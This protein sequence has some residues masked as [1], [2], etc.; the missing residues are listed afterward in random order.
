MKIT[1]PC[2]IV[3]VF[4]THFGL[5]GEER[6]HQVQTVVSPDWMSDVPAGQAAVLL[7]DFNSHPGS[8]PHRTIAQQ[9]RDARTFADSPPRLA[10]YPSWKP[11]LGIDH[12]FVNEV[13]HVDN[14]RVVHSAQTGMASDHLPLRAELSWT[15]FTNFLGT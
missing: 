5:G 7:G 12:I 8:R 3:N 11:V 15:E 4:T 1:T 10:T 13:L 2:G 6:W 9:M 14:V